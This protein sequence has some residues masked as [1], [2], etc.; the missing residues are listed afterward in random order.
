MPIGFSEEKV[1]WI[2]L[3]LFFIVQTV[4]G[5]TQTNPDSALQSI[6]KAIEGTP[7]T[8][9]QAIENGLRNATSVQMAE[10]SLMVAQGAVRRDRGFYDPELFFNLKINQQ[11]APTASFFAGSPTLV[12]RQFNSSSGLRINLPT[13]T[14]FELAINTVQLKTNSL[15]AFLN[16]EYNAVGTF[17]F[18][19][20]LLRG[21]T[22]SGRKQLTSSE[23]QLDAAQAR[24]DQQ[25]LTTSAEV[26]RVYWDLY[27]A[28]RDYAVQ[29]LTRNRADAFLKEAELRAKSG[30]V[31][32]NQVANA[33][34][35]LAEQELG[36]LRMDEQLGRLSDRLSSLIGLRPE[37]SAQRFITLN[38]P[39]G[40]FFVE[41][42]ETLIEN[43]RKSNLDLLAAEKD[44]EAVDALANAA[45]WEAFPS[46]DLVGSIG[47]NGLA[48][49]SRQ[50]VFGGD[51]LSLPPGRVGGF[52]DAV[53]QVVEHKFPNWSVGVEVTVPIGFRSGLGERDRLN[54][55][56]AFNQH[57][58][59]DLSRQLEEQIRDIYRVLSHG[60]ARLTAAREG[61]EA[62]QEQVR[63]GLVEFRDGRVTAFE[64]VRLGEDFAIAQRRYSEALVLT[65][66]AAATL[67]QLTSN[68][69]SVRMVD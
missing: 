3:L 61:V 26:E 6:L 28:E 60:K 54:A 53:S 44:V 51:T 24:Y 32:P 1:N 67:R 27:A 23:R 5:Q 45:K 41:P 66:K 64:L 34:T 56:V 35:F 59:T 55:L 52:G 13:G 31:G 40:D 14:E 43:A 20:P 10:A 7:L 29:K 2:F 39:P 17:S 37:S 49:T 22:A 69:N 62:A 57:R 25:V 68:E 46:L 9:Q 42:L 63:I 19:Q 58:Y 47:G 15:F 18:R 21:F 11:E 38:N 65:A 12:T 48:G 16:P 36:L 50:V 8:L 4:I 30:L 33:K